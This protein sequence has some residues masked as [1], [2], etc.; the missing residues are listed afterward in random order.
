MAEAQQTAV[1]LWFATVLLFKDKI[2][3]PLSIY[4]EIDAV[5][6]KQRHLCSPVASWRTLAAWTLDQRC[7]WAAH[8]KS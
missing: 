4:L 1:L 2:G 8:C 5:C 7:F 6:C 3:R